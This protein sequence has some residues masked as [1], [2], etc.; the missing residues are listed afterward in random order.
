MKANPVIAGKNTTKINS[1][2]GEIQGDKVYENSD[3]TNPT[4]GEQVTKFL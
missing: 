2:R 4:S 3:S 1:P